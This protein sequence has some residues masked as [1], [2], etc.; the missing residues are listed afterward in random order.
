MTTLKT[1]PL[2]RAPLPSTSVSVTRPSTDARR[3][4]AR[5]HAHVLG[6]GGHRGRDAGLVVGG[7]R[8]LQAGQRRAQLELAEDLAEL[9]AV[10]LPRG[11]VRGVDLDRPP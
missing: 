4:S 8:V 7:Q 10:G 6:L 1:R 5:P 3:G 9:G 11:L 2:T